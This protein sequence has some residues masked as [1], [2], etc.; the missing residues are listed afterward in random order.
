MSHLFKSPL[1]Q[2]LGQESQYFSFASKAVN[3]LFPFSQN[4]VLVI[5]LA[6]GTRTELSVTGHGSYH[7]DFTYD[8]AKVDRLGHLACLVT[9]L[10]LCDFKVCFFL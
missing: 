10:G 9:E 3:L 6:W 4:C 5:G 7:V 1:L 2:P 8:D